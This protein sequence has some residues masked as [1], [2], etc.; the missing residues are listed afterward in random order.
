M[1][2]R[3]KRKMRKVIKE[4]KWNSKGMPKGQ[5]RPKKKRKK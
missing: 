1:R 2:A 4:T 3:V 5:M